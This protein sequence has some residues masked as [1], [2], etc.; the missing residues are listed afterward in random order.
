M[1][2]LRVWYCSQQLK[3]NFP[4]WFLILLLFWWVRVS[5]SLRLGWILP[6]RRRKNLHIIHWILLKWVHLDL[7][8]RNSLNCMWRWM[9]GDELLKV[10][11]NICAFFSVSR[12]LG[13]V[14]SVSKSDE[15]SHNLAD[16]FKNPDCTQKVFDKIP[17]Q[18]KKE[19]KLNY[20]MW[21]CSTIIR[22]RPLN[23]KLRKYMQRGCLYSWS[24][25]CDWG[26]WYIGF[27]L[28]GFLCEALF[29]HQISY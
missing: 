15:S 16:F 21:I 2:F 28:G 5:K 11:E 3:G 29:E 18:K 27:L 23:W 14:D 20:P 8:L 12:T 13:D 1:Y 26:E 19:Q 9:M 24:R 7:V 22:N 17:K 10:D 25:W 4:A 6:W